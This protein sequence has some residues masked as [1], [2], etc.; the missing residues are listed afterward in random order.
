MSLHSTLHILTLSMGAQ[1]GTNP[2]PFSNAVGDVLYPFSHTGLTWLCQLRSEAVRCRIK[3]QPADSP[4]L[5]ALTRGLHH[6]PLNLQP[7]AKV[8]EM[9]RGGGGECDRGTVKERRQRRGKAEKER[10]RRGSYHY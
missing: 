4:R 3:Q 10:Q 5:P 2:P 1:V 8:G 7:E 9:G 6:T